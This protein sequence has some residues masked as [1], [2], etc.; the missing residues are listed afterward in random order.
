MTDNHQEEKLRQEILGD[1]KTK[2][3]RISIVTFVVFENIF[4][5]LCYVCI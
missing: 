3:E 1:A 4:I 5:L 2:A